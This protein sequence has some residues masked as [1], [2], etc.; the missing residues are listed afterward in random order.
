MKIPCS[1]CTLLAALANLKVS[2]F[3]HRLITI[4]FFLDICYY[5]LKCTI[6]FCFVIA[7]FFCLIVFRHRAFASWLLAVCGTD[8]LIGVWHSAG[9]YFRLCGWYRLD[10]RTYVRGL[11]AVVQ[12]CHQCA[13]WVHAYSSKS[14]Q[15]WPSGNTNNCCSPNG[16]SIPSALFGEWSYGIP[17][18]AFYVW[19][20]KPG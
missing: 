3:R 4:T 19:A 8:A 14:R 12:R 5:F 2:H 11:C 20:T 16:G 18:V 17:P 15:V 1:C 7:T 13:V 6:V 9:G 10:Y